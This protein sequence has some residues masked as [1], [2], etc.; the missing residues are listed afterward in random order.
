MTPMD[1]LLSGAIARIDRARI[2]AAELL[3]GLD[4]EAAHRAPP[5]GGWSIAQCFDH[6]L[7]VG[8]GMCP[9]L[10]EAIAQARTEGRL[11]RSDRPSRIGWFDRLFIHA[12]GPARKEGARPPMPVTT[13]SVFTPGA[14]RPVVELAAAFAALQ[15]RLSELA[16]AAQGL[17][18]EGIQVPSLV[19]GK[20]RLRLGAWF[21]ALTGHQERHL[22]QA[23]RVRAGLGV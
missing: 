19:S 13:P 14:G 23:K 4:D 12:T 21:P 20:I 11:T 15:D 5:G 16:Q 8:N 10:Q 22:A 1:P 6:L 3:E 7:I 2:V 9:R 17:D 18:L